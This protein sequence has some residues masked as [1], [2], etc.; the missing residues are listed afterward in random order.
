[1]IRI[2]TKLLE[3]L[4]KE[5]KKEK[6]SLTKQLEVLVSEWMDKKEHQG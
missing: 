6:R 2:E 1:M 5:A 3:K 4:K